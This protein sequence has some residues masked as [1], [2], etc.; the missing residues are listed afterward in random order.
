MILVTGGFGFIGSHLV[1]RLLGGGE[2]VHV[3]DDLSSS[4][5]LLSDLVNEWHAR[6]VP[7]GALTYDLAPIVEWFATKSARDASPALVYHL[8]SVVGPAGVLPHAGRIVTRIVA[9]TALVAEFALSRRIR[10]VN[11][12]TSEIYGGTNGGAC[13]EDTPRTI[14]DCIAPR[15]EYAVGK[16]AGET[17]LIALK[18]EGLDAVIV[19]PFNVAGPRQGGNGGFVLPRFV[20]QALAGKP[21]TVF[22]SGKQQ[23]SFTH[24]ADII[25]GLVLLAERGLSGTAYNLGNPANR[26]T[27]N[28]LAE[29]V[30]GET[31]SRAG[32][33]H[34][35]PHDIYGQTYIEAKD[36]WPLA[37]RA[38]ELG[39]QPIHDVSRTV[40]DVVC[41]LRGMTDEE[42]R[43]VTGI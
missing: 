15:I 22:G 4:P 23:R 19:R 7:T 28:S 26:V 1:G 39:W 42:R 34:V 31:G 16:L 32:T 14:S 41:W 9:D 10:L 36:K 12:S 18:A 24:V 20:G 11:V 33:V 2:R 25:D 40:R 21:L 6:G 30:L 5:L 3:V 8:A 27:I 37:G 17:A 13:R 38:F 29:L 35:D 43:R